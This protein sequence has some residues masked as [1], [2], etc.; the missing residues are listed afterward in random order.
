[1]A[2]R[3]VLILGAGIGGLAAALSFHRRGWPV[4]VVEQA[5]AITEVGAGL[6]ISPNGGAVLRALGL[7]AGFEAGSVRAQAVVLSD[8]KR[9]GDVLRLDL[10]RRGDQYFGLMHRADLIGLL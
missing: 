7:G 2:D 3:E 8:W 5:T 6:Q 1:M 10:R 4:R 9:P